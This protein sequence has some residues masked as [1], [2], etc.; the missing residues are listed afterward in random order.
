[1]G[2]SCFPRWS[3]KLSLWAWKCE[4]WP[5]L[6]PAEGISV[7][8]LSCSPV[9]RARSNSRAFP[10]APSSSGSGQKCQGV[11][12]QYWK[13]SWCCQPSSW[14]FHDTTPWHWALA[15]PAS[16]GS[17]ISAPQ[18]SHHVTHTLLGPQH[19]RTLHEAGGI[20]A[21]VPLEAAG[22]ALKSWHLLRHERLWR[23]KSFCSSGRQQGE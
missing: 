8:P 3:S 1:M 22:A 21:E 11:S 23:G 10:S 12:H 16:C 7:K 17:V 18:V 9:P 6:F 15:L 2:V 14:L 20:K 13:G 19:S 5:Q 4:Y